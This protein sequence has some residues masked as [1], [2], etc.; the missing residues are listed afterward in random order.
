MYAY[1]QIDQTLVDERVI[2][3]RDQTTRFLAG[4]LDEEVYKQLRLRNGLYVQR[5]APMLRVAVPYGV[6]DSTQMRMLA[7]ISRIYDKSYAHVTTRQ[8]FQFNWPTI[9]SVPDILA[10]LAK[11][12]MHAI[13]TSGNC[14]RNVTSDPL[15]GAAVDEVEDPRVWCEIIRQW[16]TLHPEF[17]YLPRKF[18]FAVT[19]STEDRVALQVHD[20]GLQV[21][22]NNEGEVGFKVYVGGGMGRT[23][24]IGKVIRDFLPRTDFLSY[25]D[26]IL[27]VYNL[28][29]RR[30]NIYKARIKILVNAIGINKF[31]DMVEEEWIQVRDSDLKLTN[32]RIQTITDAF[33]F[34]QYQDLPATDKDHEQ[35]LLTNPIFSSWC[36]Q[37]TRLHKKSGYRIVYVSL[38]GHGQAPGDVNDLQMDG[39]ANLADEFSMGE[40]RTTYSQ[41]MVLAHV[42]QTQLYQLWRKLNKLKLATPN[43]DTVTD[44]ICCPGFDFC[45]L[46]NATSIDVSEDIMARFEKLDRLYDVG[47]LNIKISGCMNACGHHHVGHIGLL[48]VDKKGEDWYQITLGG[49]ASNHTA[50][51]KVLGPSVE[52]S[53]IGDSVEKII[54]VYLELRECDENFLQTLARV[55]RSPFKE[56]VYVD[57]D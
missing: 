49:S 19:G 27:R 31:R 51:G 6:L 40:I 47:E 36:R 7:N 38:K 12:Q 13:Q 20:I 46:A 54:E 32:A 1:S 37:N 43:I 18:K 4:K 29:G 52:K 34:I 8:N 45:S 11:V 44:L 48:G 53:K 26:A 39:I 17:S 56:Q 15:A 50:L 33:N 2:Q 9:E 57:S 23:P 35:N 21:L 28:Y 5:H 42:Q 30:D 10:D 24:V 16:S 41:N 3:F 25:L 22:R 14:I 55:G